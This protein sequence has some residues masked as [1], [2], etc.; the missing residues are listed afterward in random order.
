MDWLGVR[1]N[2]WARLNGLSHCLE[3]VAYPLLGEAIVSE[4]IVHDLEA[5]NPDDLSLLPS[6]VRN[7]LEF[8]LRTMPD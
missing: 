6:D 1:S 8:A 7:A 2:T 4:V 5:L 3:A